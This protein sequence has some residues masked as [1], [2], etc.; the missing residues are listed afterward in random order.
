[1]PMGEACAGTLANC[2]LF[3]YEWDYLK[4]L[5]RYAS[6]HGVDRAP[7]WLLAK[8]FLSTK[9]YIDDIISLNN[10]EFVRRRYM[11]PGGAPAPDDITGIYPK[12]FLTLNV[13]RAGPHAQ[14]RRQGRWR[15]HA[16][17]L[18]PDL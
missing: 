5:V 4:R 6:A 18:H 12:Q 13:C 11:A 3:T 8:K 15:A 17:P 9:R 14:E 7:R 16:G 2:Y 1:M 10:D